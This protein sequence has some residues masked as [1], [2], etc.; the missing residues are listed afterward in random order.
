MV[1]W[2]KQ[3]NE[4]QQERDER[5]DKFIHHPREPDL[6]LPTEYDPDLD[7]EF[8]HHELA[9]T[10]TEILEDLQVTPTPQHTPTEDAIE[11]LELADHTSEGGWLSRL[12]S[13]LSQST[14]RLG[15]GI[16][17][18]FT[19]RKLDEKILQYLEDLLI[20]SDLGTKTAAKIVSEFSFKK[21][22]K[23]IEPNEVRREMAVIVSGMLEGVTKPLEITK[24]A[25]G[26]FVIIVCGVNGAGKTTT[27]GKLAYDWHVKQRKSVMIA[28]ADTFRAAA[29]DQLEIWA[30]RAHVPLFKKDMGADADAVVFEAYEKAN[31]ENV[32][33]LMIY[34]AGRMQKK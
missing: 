17:D 27:I 1:F 16:S 28:A 15:Q 11:A 19:K 2:R 25:N 33:K 26:P 23:D 29:V 21:F 20:S 24:P 7:P 5:D 22:E 12:S 6:E 13:G 8:A 9:P 31:K 4:G 3:K 30:Q 18:I 10:E 34:T 14:G 32:E